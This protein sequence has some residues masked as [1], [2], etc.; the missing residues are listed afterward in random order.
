MIIAKGENSKKKI[1][2]S[3]SGDISWWSNWPVFVQAMF[4]P[5][6]SDGRSNAASINMMLGTT[7]HQRTPPHDN[8]GN[9]AAIPKKAENM[10]PKERSDAPI[11]VSL[12][13]KNSCD[14][15]PL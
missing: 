9:R 14:I 2:P 15:V 3:N 10:S 12:L 11:G 8:S 13:S 1:I 7:D 4:M 5:V 6:R